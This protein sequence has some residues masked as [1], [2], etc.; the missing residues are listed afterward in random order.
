MWGGDVVDI[1]YIRQTPA[2]E[3]NNAV[4]KTIVNDRNGNVKEYFYDGGNRCTMMREYTGRANP[5][6]PTTETANRAVNKLRATDPDYFET[7]YEYNS[8]YKRTRTIYPNGDITEN[9]YGADMNPAVSARFRG[10]L[11]ETRHTPGS[12]VPAGDQS[13][14]VDK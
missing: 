8:D 10:N 12:H 9:I 13:L 11:I 2:P 3:N 1:A 4:V 7:R 5:T 14:L 6:Q